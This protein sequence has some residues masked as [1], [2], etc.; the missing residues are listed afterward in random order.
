[1]GD[2]PN[3]FAVQNANFLLAISTHI[4]IQQT[5]YSFETWIRE[6]EVIMIDIDRAK[7]KKHTIHVNMPV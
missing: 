7:M 3:N 6:A 4:S 2:R 1:M 5:S